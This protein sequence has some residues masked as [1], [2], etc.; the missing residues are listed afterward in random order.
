MKIATKKV[1]NVTVVLLSRQ[2]GD[3]DFPVRDALSCMCRSGE[4]L[5]LI[6]LRQVADIGSS[7]VGEL[8]AAHKTVID[9]GGIVKYLLKAD[10]PVQ[11]VI[12]LVRLNEVFDCY[13]DERAALESF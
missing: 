11:E 4:R 3:R 12:N 5:F 9:S 10:S 6:D 1:S 13:E 7:E 8:A 2:R